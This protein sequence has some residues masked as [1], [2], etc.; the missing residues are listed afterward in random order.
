MRNYG[1]LV[2]FNYEL[3]LCFPML[4]PSL[5]P[6]NQWFSKIKSDLSNLKGQHSKEHPVN[7]IINRLQTKNLTKFSLKYGYTTLNYDTQRNLRN[8]VIV[9]RYW[10][11]S[12]IKSLPKTIWHGQSKSKT[13]PLFHFLYSSVFTPCYLSCLI[14]QP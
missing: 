14:K 1:T 7:D 2:G 11:T 10:S 4:A 3:T 9:P 13:L 12:T 5:S 8:N 6:V